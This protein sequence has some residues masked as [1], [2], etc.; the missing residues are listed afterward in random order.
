L[1]AN[2]A[3]RS[4][5]ISFCQP[6][7]KFSWTYGQTSDVSDVVWLTGVVLHSPVGWRDVRLNQHILVEN[8]KCSQWLWDQIMPLYSPSGSTLQWASFAVS[9]I[10]CLITA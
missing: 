7:R 9:S 2:Y 1:E 6:E 4:T 5:T 10:I 3:T 8:Q